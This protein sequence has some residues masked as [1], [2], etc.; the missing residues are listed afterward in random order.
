MICQSMRVSEPS[1]ASNAYVWEWFDCGEEGNSAGCPVIDC[2]RNNHRSV[3]GA[4]VQRSPA[5]RYHLREAQTRAGSAHERRPCVGSVEKILCLAKAARSSGQST[6]SDLKKF[7][8]KSA[9]EKSR[10]KSCAA[11]SRKRC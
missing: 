9:S 4:F 10:R 2:P 11:A 6:E 8:A 1:C 7:R 5:V 3:M